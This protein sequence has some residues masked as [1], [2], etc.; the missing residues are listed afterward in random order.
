MPELPEV[1]VAARNLTRWARGRRVR[2][3][4]CR[5]PRALGGGRP[6]D[7]K[8]LAGTRLSTVERTGKNLL[9]TFRA[10]AK[11]RVGVW[12]HLGMTGKWTLRK[13]AE[14]APRFSRVRVDFEGGVSLHFV[15]M[16]LFGFFRV[17][18]G[19]A[20]AELPVIAALGPDPLR[21]GIDVARLAARLALRRRLPIK[22]A[23]MDQALI[24]GV[25]NIQASEG[26]FRAAI[27]P[28]RSAA[29]LTPTEVR[30]L[31]R[32]L[33]ASFQYTLRAF[34]E[35]GA[36]Q[37]VAYVEETGT[38]NPF[39]VYDRAGVRCPRCHEGTITRV[40]QAGRSTYFCP[41]CQL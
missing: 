27:D 38:R 26:L 28:R 8:Q 40:V 36:D 37:D 19:A 33:L 9:L 23:I 32:G 3:I 2:S 29:T 12:S 18:P 17:V 13:P 34:A 25:G 30:K 1:E 4:S 11:Q 7:L 41:V 14:P 39:K 35:A 16:R 15:D 10:G 5:E 20:F 21:D 31:A 24:P 6:A 22:V